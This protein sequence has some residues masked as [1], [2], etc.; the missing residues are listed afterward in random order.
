MNVRA[1]SMTDLREEALGCKVGLVLADAIKPRALRSAIL[2]E[3]VHA[4]RL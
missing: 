1:E 3:A 2:A 4:S